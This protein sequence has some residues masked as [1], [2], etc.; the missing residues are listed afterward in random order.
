MAIFH[1]WGMTPSLNQADIREFY[2][3]GTR[4][5]LLMNPK[6]PDFPRLQ[7]LMYELLRAD[8]VDCKYSVNAEYVAICQ[9]ILK[10]EW[11]VAKRETLGE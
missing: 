7:E 8:S 1:S 9:R 5:E 10:R 2:E 3:H 4:I 11:D 6:D